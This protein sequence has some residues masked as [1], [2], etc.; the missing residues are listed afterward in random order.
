MPTRFSTFSVFGSSSLTLGV[1]CGESYV[2]KDFSI[3][4]GHLFVSKPGYNVASGSSDFKELRG[5]K[6]LLRSPKQLSE[7]SVV[8]C[9]WSL[10]QLV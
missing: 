10:L 7:L 6:G 5:S 8:S 1:S 2:G 3:F 4:T 9:F